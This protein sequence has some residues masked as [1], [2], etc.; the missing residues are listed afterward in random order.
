MA[1]IEVEIP[2]NILAFMKEFQNWHGNGDDPAKY[3]QGAIKV[4]CEADLDYI[5]EKAPVKAKKLV[6][7]LR[8][9]N[10]V[11]SPHCFRPEDL[12]VDEKWPK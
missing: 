4:S 9:G 11:M 3:I 1:T 12:E 2:D 8:L 6:R 10:I 7:D 5:L